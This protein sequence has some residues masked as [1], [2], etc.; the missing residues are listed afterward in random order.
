MLSIE[1]KGKKVN[2]LNCYETK[3]FSNG[4]KF[5]TISMGVKGTESLADFE[6]SL[7][8]NLNIDLVEDGNIIFAITQ[9]YTIK[10]IFRNINVINEGFTVNFQK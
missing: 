9:D 2:V 7:G 8:Q 6:S 3:L 10:E 5:E 1:F 4:Q